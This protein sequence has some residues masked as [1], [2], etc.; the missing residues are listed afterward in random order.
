NAASLRNGLIGTRC[1]SRREGGCQPS[2]HDD[3][4]AIPG[5][6]S[7]IYITIAGWEIRLGLRICLG[8][9]KSGALPNQLITFARRLYQA[10]PIK[11]R[12]LP[13]AALDQTGT[14]QLAG[15][16]CERWPLDTQHFGEKILC[17]R[18]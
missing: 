1:S 17:V 12:D 7:V 9:M 6:L 14:F 10:W 13:P 5:A 16:M 11:D 8:Q 2:R 18:G 4:A 3:F 15:G